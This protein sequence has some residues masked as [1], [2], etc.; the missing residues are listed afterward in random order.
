MTTGVGLT[1][2]LFVVV[3][4]LGTPAAADEYFAKPNGSTSANCLS[5]ANACTIERVLELAAFSAGDT[6]ILMDGTYTG[7]TSMLRPGAVAPGK[8]GTSGNPITVKA[9][10]DGN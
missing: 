8:S 10:N 1:R 5:E 4:L 9:L 7:T 6:L 3:C 2:A